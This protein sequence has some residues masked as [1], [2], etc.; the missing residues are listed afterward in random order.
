MEDKRV[1]LQ[2]IKRQNKL[3]VVLSKT[4]VRTLLKAPKYL[5]HRLM[6]GMLYG[7]GLRSYELCALRLSDVDFD[8]MSVFVKKQ[9]GK[10]DRYV[11]LSRHLARGLKKYIS[12]GTKLRQVCQIKTPL[13][14]R[15][16]RLSPQTKTGSVN[17]IF[18]P[19]LSA[20]R[21][22]S[23]CPQLFYSL[24]LLKSVSFFPL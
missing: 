19:G 13:Q 5:K 7:C 18:I 3:P 14:I 12:T 21:I 1:K 8:R 16:R 2:Q 9:K 20:G 17:K 24:L 10:L 23:Y 15:K 4:E 22:L 11:P 6:L